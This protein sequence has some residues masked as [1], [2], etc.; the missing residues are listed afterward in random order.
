M[1]KEH[2]LV[3]VSS[4][5]SN[6]K[7]I[8]AAARMAKAYQGSFTA[9]YVE[10]PNHA[11]MTKENKQR[12]QENLQYAQELGAK[13][14]I[15]Y[16][17]DVSFQIAEFSRLSGVTSIVIGRSSVKRR[18]WP[19]QMTLSERLISNVPN[20][21]IHIIPDSE[22]QKNYFNRKSIPKW[23]WKNTLLSGIIMTLATF[24]GMVF[25]NLGFTEANIIMVYIL[26]VLVISVVT[27]HRIHSMISSVVS[28]FLFNFF[29]TI[30]KYTFVAYHHGYPVTFLI[31]FL[32][33]F[34][35][36]TLAVRLKNNAKQ[37]AQAAYRTKLLLE[38][39]QLLQQAKD[40]K[41]ILTAT[42]NQLI[43]LLRKNVILYA[44][45]ENNLEKPQLFSNAGEIIEKEFY[46]DKEQNVAK[47]VLKN[48]TRAGATTSVYPGAKCIYYSIRVN[49]TVYGVVGI[50][51]NGQPLEAFSNSVM[52]SIL[53]ECALML[54]NRKNAREKEEAKL[55]A[56]NEKLRANLLRTISHD[57]RTPLTSISGHASN[58][59]SNG[60]DFDVATKLR[61]YE[62]IH[63]DSMWLISLVENLLSITRIEDGTI[64]LHLAPELVDEIIAE[65]LSHVNRN[66]K[67]R[68]IEV[69]IEEELIFVRAD[70]KLMVQVLI[71]IVDNA[72][73]YSPD[74]SDVKILVE[75]NGE[76]VIVRVVDQGI[77]ISDEM[78]SKV[79]DMFYSGA[80][81]VADSRRSLGLGLYLCKAIIHAHG[82]TITV[83]DNIP[84]GTVFSFTLPRE[85]VSLHE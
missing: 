21:D 81:K 71:N 24:I 18:F 1:K 62:D 39:N 42:V 70:A 2:I 23:S 13:I 22:I 78:K 29:F 75:K 60:D 80:N 9:L 30:P 48:N 31:M 36:S 47:W 41:A 49:T 74:G 19:G 55:M 73:K 5:P 10:T 68:K 35:T 40:E 32:A 57:L 64:S 17:D 12:L 14:E 54:E 27:S 67:A 66:E 72:I 38:T 51:I 46:D 37:A 33:A 50:A 4:A 76:Q 82:G 59:L 44:V 65:A 52:L 84:Q 61:M 85:E 63:D 16:G 45:E 56:Q 7:I 20:L 79:F 11:S 43:K 34:I 28:V 15:V 53:G 83:S 77:G 8:R 69:Q 6:A 58:L 25:S 3:G 26:G